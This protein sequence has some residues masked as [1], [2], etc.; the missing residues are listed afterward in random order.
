MEAHR[1]EISALVHS[2]FE[3]L[4]SGAPCEVLEYGRRQTVR[5]ARRV[6]G[7]NGRVNLWGRGTQESDSEYE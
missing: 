6:T 2:I 3:G 7:A 1:E 4:W 5:A